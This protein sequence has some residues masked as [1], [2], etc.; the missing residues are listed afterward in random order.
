M[1]L[2]LVYAIIGAALVLLGAD[3]LTDGSVGLAARAG[4]S[5][6]V[7][8]LTVV[9]FGTSLPEFIVSL[10]A[11]VGS[12]D[13]ATAL[14]VSNIVGSNVFNTLVIAG[15]SAAVCPIAISRTTVNKDIPLCI[16]ASV[17][18]AALALDDVM[19]GGSTRILTRGDG[20]ALLGFFAIF[21]AYTFSL[22][23]KD[24]P[25]EADA[26]AQSTQPMSA[27]RIAIY[28]VLGLGGLIGGGQLFVEGA[29]GVAREAGVSEAVIGLTLV[30]GGTSLPELATSIVAARKGQSALAIGNVVGSNLFNI[31]WILGACSCITPLAVIGLTPIDFGMLIASSLLFWLFARSS[32]KLSRWEGYLMVTVYIAYLAWLI[33]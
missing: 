13:A 29:S 31:F 6:M 4:M 17:V 23:Q 30:A 15:V 12:D 9:A 8:G 25:A 33:H 28:I 21:M 11:A 5:E 20:I 7:I 26:D 19:S 16:M 27:T 24:K 14:S 10:L 1:L 22:A 3:K 32:Y 2:Y 18:L